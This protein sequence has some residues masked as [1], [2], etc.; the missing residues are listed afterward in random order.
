MI[1]CLAFGELLFDV[2]PTHKKIGG[3]PLNFAAHFSRL[4]GESYLLSA[5]GRDALGEELLA[6]VAGL[7]VS[8][9][10]IEVLDG[11]P[12]ATCRVSYNADEPVYSLPTGVSYDFIGAQT[13]ELSC[14]LLYFGT[15]AVRGEV[16][17][18]SLLSLLSSCV[19]KEKFLD[20]NL[21]ASFYDE[22][23]VREL[24]CRASSLKLN[25]DEY[26]YC[27]RVFGINAATLYGFSA[28]LAEKF[29]IGLIIVTLDKDGC[30]I[31]ERRSKS[32]ITAPIKEGKFVSA[33][34]AGDSFSAC[35]M[36]NYLSGAPLDLCTERATALASLVV[37]EEAAVP[38][39]DRKPFV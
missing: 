5:V 27:N 36:Y 9:S 14:D 24:L 34:G 1:R 25:R 31:Y 30:A 26:E 29:D 23:T 4:G 3:A 7:G 18:A 32:F 10:H 19:A 15:L 8:T 2:Y 17:R 21:R 6:Q 13:K 20:L 37:S 38:E 22:Q 35:F 39:Y 16:S 12:S 33:V 11:V 28:S